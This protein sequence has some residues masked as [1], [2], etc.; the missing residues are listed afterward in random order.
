MNNEDIAFN[1]SKW[2][3][4]ANGVFGVNVNR[5][6]IYPLI[7]D[8]AV[9]RIIDPIPEESKAWIWI[10]DGWRTKPALALLQE[11]GSAEIKDG[12]TALV[13]ATNENPL[14]S[15]RISQPEGHIYWW[16]T[17]WKHTP[18]IVSRFHN[19]KLE[20]LHRNDDSEDWAPLPLDPEDWDIQLFGAQNDTLYIAGYHGEETKG[21]Y[22][23]DIATGK[24]G[25]LLFRDEYYDFSDSA[26]F[27][28]YKNRLVGIHYERDVPAVV[29]FTPE[30]ESIQNTLDT[31]LPG[32]ANIIYDWS[33]DFT[34]HLVYSYSD[35]T[36]PEYLLLDL[37]NKSLSEMGVFDWEKLIQDRK[38]QKSR[39]SRYKLKKEL[40]DPKVAQERFH[41]ISPIHHTEKIKIPI[42]IIHG[43]NDKNVSVRH[44][45]QLASNSEKRGLEHETLFIG[46]E[47]HNI[48]D[49]KKRV[50]VYDHIVQ[51]LD[52]H[53]R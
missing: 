26:G 24:I 8:D 46:G 27:M 44:S 47:G 48:F 20:Y 37:A 10:K 32:R 13:A 4:Y 51:F 49:V 25:D 3:A 2:D 53:M 5:S 6:S 42:L 28:V 23:F 38:Q 9:T 35:V 1:V 14:I 45:K 11:S 43:K 18:R 40:G 31:A 50:K 15:N 21:L 30:M 19:E 16:Y 52:E 17:D 12:L 29:W 34:R 22:E 33:D 7:A 36:P 41:E 39:Y